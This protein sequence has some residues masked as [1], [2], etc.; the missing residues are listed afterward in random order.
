[1]S[2]ATRIAE[3]GDEGHCCNEV[4][5]AQ[6]HQC[7]NYRKHTPWT[8]LYSQ[9]VGEAP[10]PFLG[11]FDSVSVFVTSN[12]AALLLTPDERA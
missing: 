9:G 2:K 8:A 4:K 10:K 5:G 1:M 7:L 11:I 12:Y 3:L 6:T